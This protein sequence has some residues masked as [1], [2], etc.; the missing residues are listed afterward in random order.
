MAV[1]PQAL[2]I[3]QTSTKLLAQAAQEERERQERLRLLKQKEEQ[4]KLEAFGGAQKQI[5]E[6]TK[7]LPYQVQQQI[8][9]E[10]LGQIKQGLLKQ[11]MSAADYTM[12]AADG[13][14]QAVNT[15]GAY[16]NYLK[17]GEEIARSKKDQFYNEN[18][19]NAY[20][21]KSIYKTVQDPKTGQSKMV[22][23]DP[24]ELGNVKD[25]I[26]AEIKSNRY[27]YFNMAA[28]TKNFGETVNN[29]KPYITKSTEMTNPYSKTYFTTDVEVKNHPWTK[30][31]TVKDEKTGLEIPKSVL[32]TEEAKD[33]A[34]YSTVV[35]P[36]TGKPAQVM[37]DRGANA[38]YSLNPAYKDM[39]EY[40]ASQLIDQ[41]NKQKGFNP[42]AITQDDINN[43]AINPLDEGNKKVFSSIFLAE[44]P[45]M[46]QFKEQSDAK[47]TVHKE[48]KNTTNVNLGGDN[49]S[50]IA[51]IKTRVDGIVKGDPQYNGDKIYEG[52]R[53]GKKAQLINVTDQFKF[54][55]PLDKDSDKKQFPEKIIY[56]KTEN[57]FE[58]WGSG[59]SNKGP[60]RAIMYLSPVAM[61]DVINE[62]AKLP[63][64]NEKGKFQHGEDNDES[65]AAKLIK[66]AEEAK[67]GKK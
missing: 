62:E 26:E 29:A 40:G 23:K 27:P 52:M 21:A 59:K 14:A 6:A 16:A 20:V 50:K 3:D 67:K 44:H 47:T 5:I 18:E 12:L 9:S 51:L 53:S 36:R 34:G 56:N 65:I 61:T 54:R 31:I 39:A 63:L 43:G 58:I 7:A 13:V 32:D 48:N 57:V 22:V 64:T 46:Q 49:D 10:R 45:D 42:S 15:A 17:Q 8:L 19:I 35:D 24:S 2:E 1:Y 37:S 60:A 66:K 4:S 28:V 11:G 30:V 41:F 25:N 55:L 33:I 38:I